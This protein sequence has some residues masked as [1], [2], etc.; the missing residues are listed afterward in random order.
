M[1]S[2]SRN[3]ANLIQIPYPHLT[4]KILPYPLAKFTS[5]CKNSICAQPEI[6][7]RSHMRRDESTSQ[8]VAQHYLRSGLAFFVD[9]MVWTFAQAEART[10]NTSWLPNTTR[11]VWD[12]FEVIIRRA[13]DPH[14]NNVRW[15]NGLA[16]AK[17]SCPNWLAIAK[18]SWPNGLAIAKPS[19]P[20]WLAIAKPSW[21][22]GLA[23][24]KPSWPNR[25]A[26]AKP[27]A[28]WMDWQLRPSQVGWMDWQL[29]SQAGWM[30][31][32]CQG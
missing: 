3:C 24:A 32:N 31:S 11:S 19:C 5:D 28:G 10:D 27:L 12:A 17:P 23:I 6:C 9:L 29:P 30:D 4:T 8:V 16:I 15:L 13:Y 2:C 21:P 22:N 7:M 1:C 18:P 20:N 14:P 25:L 26:I